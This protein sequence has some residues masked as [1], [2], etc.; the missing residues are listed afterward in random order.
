MLFP[1][2]D[3]RADASYTETAWQKV[4]EGTVGKGRK[5][6][7]E[8]PRFEWY[9]EYFGGRPNEPIVIDESW[10]QHIFKSWNPLGIRFLSVVS[11]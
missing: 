3:G 2:A 9:E 4:V 8:A 1:S 5:R 10:T 7:R 6:Q 11:V